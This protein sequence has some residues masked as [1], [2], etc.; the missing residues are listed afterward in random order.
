MSIPDN[1]F[2]EIRRGN[3]PQTNPTMLEVVCSSFR[4]IAFRLDKLIDVLERG[5]D[6][7]A[8]APITGPGQAYTPITRMVEMMR[9]DLASYPR[10]HQIRVI[11]N[12]GDKI[13]SN[14]LPYSIPI[15]VTNQDNAQKL[16]YGASTA[17]MTN[18]PIIEPEASKK[19]ILSP[20]ADLY[21]VVIGADIT[22]AISN[23]D[24]PM[25]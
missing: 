1:V 20:N 6:A 18:A 22:V 3:F 25:V 16:Y 7:E 13:M 15:L 12:T 14:P 8:L 11:P 23:L 17:T 9:L 2:K 4:Q 19:I 10:D 21:G 5:P 24:L